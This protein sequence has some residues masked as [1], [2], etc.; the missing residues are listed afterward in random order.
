MIENQTQVILNQ[1]YKSNQ[2]FISQKMQINE[3][4]LKYQRNL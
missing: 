3:E 4:H 1:I 2:I